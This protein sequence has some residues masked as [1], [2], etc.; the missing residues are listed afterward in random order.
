MN[1]I[2]S[3]IIIEFCIHF[4][5]ILV[6][7]TDSETIIVAYIFAPFVVTNLVGIL[8]LIMNK[9][10]LGA[11]IFMYSS[12]AFIPI[13]LIGAIGAR[14]IID[15]IKKEMNEFKIKKSLSKMFIVSGIIVIGISIISFAF[16][17]R[18]TSLG[19]GILALVFG[20]VQKDKILVAFFENH[21]EMRIAPLRSVTLIKY[22][23]INRI[24]T[25]NEK[26][27]FLHGTIEGKE[28]KLRIPIALIE[29]TEKHSL[30]ET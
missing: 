9:S 12:Y 21:L 15:K 25:I 11:R 14:N 4:L 20:F 8:Y 6:L 23:D 28:K 3:K 22:N 30:L 16:T 13:G 1:Y 5:V 17:G 29:N 19:F 7:L 10:M 18:P 2:N 27:I 24:E 26:K